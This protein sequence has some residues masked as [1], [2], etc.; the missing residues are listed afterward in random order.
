MSNANP[1]LNLIRNVPI[2]DIVSA[3][4]HRTLRNPQAVRDMAAAMQAGAFDGITSEA[5]LIGI[6][7]SGN[8]LRAVECL[9]GHHR[10]IAA[11]KAGLWRVV[12]DIPDGVVETRLDGVRADD[13]TY[14]VEVRWVPASSVAESAIPLEDRPPV[15]PEWGAKGDTV[16]IS[17][18]ISS[19][20][21][22]IPKDQQGVPLKQLA[23]DL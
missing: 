23:A 18:A 3:P 7:S 9:D 20:D 11:L 1:H 8:G 6:F 19:I 16:M 5:I 2:G 12:G 15:P 17:G 14:K 21:D 13:P 10:L 4:G 22:V